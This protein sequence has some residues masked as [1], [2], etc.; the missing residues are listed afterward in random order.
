MTSNEPPTRH[1]ER[2]Q[3][4]LDLLVGVSVFLVA[5]GIVLA[6]ASGMADPVVEDQ[7]SPLATD[8]TAEL[9]TEGMFAPADA[10]S[11]LD[12]VCVVGFFEASMGA[13]T[14]AIPY[15]ESESDLTARLGL[16]PRYTVNV[17]IRRNVTGDV[18]PEVLCTDGRSVD[19][20]PGPTRLA[21]G[22]P[23]P[24]AGSTVSARRAASLGGTDV[25]VE[26]V[27]W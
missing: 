2:G 3:T 6:A 12:M 27:L 11:S 9:V 22:P 18:A 13:G 4:N 16:S 15:D 8:R 1:D 20:C 19:A 25:T 23:P 5:V 26:V 21:A 14:C 24:D 7:A 10:S 17:T